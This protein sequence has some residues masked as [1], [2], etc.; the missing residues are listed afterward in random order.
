MPKERAEYCPVHPNVKI[1]ENEYLCWCL[2]VASYDIPC[3]YCEYAEVKSGYNQSPKLSRT[4]GRK[5]DNPKRRLVKTKSDMVVSNQK[6]PG[7]ID[8]QRG[9]QGPEV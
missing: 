6:A 3:S 7:F 2:T 4:Q 8:D 9:K 5:T 1:I